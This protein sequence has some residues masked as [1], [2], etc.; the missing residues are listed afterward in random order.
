MHDGGSQCVLQRIFGQLEVFEPGDQCRQQP[1]PVRA[2]QGI[3][4]PGYG[5]R[6]GGG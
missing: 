2:R 5:L 6:I 3:N 4:G 1:P